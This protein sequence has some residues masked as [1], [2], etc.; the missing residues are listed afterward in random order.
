[1]T[2]TQTPNRYRHFAA[3]DLREDERISHYMTYSECC[4]WLA[5]QGWPGAEI[6]NDADCAWNAR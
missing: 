6:R 4:D 5:E 1:M 3:Y 2:T